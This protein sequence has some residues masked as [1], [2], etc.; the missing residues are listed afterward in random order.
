MNINLAESL[1]LERY[2]TIPNSGACIIKNS[3]SLILG[4]VGKYGYAVFRL[5]DKGQ[6]EAATRYDSSLSVIDTA[7]NKVISDFAD[8]LIM[9]D[10]K[11][12]SLYLNVFVDEAKFLEY[13][14]RAGPLKM[15]L[16][17]FKLFAADSFTF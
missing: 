10:A 17:S 16:K 12:P 9:C 3:G 11:W 15:A 8:E 1:F 13:S 6:F 14:R 7:Y 5:T 4:C 2:D